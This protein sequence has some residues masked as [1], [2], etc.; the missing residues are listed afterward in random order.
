VRASLTVGTMAMV[1]S[2]IVI[3]NIL[4]A[5]FTNQTRQS[6]ARAPYDISVFMP[7]QRSMVLPATLQAQVATSLSI[8]TR[9]YLGPVQVSSPVGTPALWHQERMSLY[10]VTPAL[11]S[12]PPMGRD[13]TNRVPQFPND[14]AAWRSVQ[15]DPGWVFWTRFNTDVRLTFVAPQG[16]VTRSV[17][18]D[19]GDPILDGI[20]GSPQAL[21]PFGNLPLGTTVLIK[22]KP[23]VDPHL[24]SAQLRQALLPE[25]AEVTAI[26]DLLR[27]RGVAFEN[28]ASVPI[29]FMRM[30]MVI[31]IL[32]LASLA[33]TL[34]LIYAAVLL[35]TFGPALAAAHIP[36]AQA[37]RLQE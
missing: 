9:S 35:T 15:N 14:A 28:F 20:V 16:L 37:L 10:E 6:D 19:F 24:L 18:G 23:G 12:R 8:P 34:A 17:A 36:P 7:A 5:E 31:G 27:Q 13:M 30:G 33:G 1:L 3:Y 22:A 11:V 2:V 25:G 21:A 29:L 32:S 4:I 26:A